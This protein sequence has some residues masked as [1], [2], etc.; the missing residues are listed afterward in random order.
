MKANFALSLS[1]DGI[2][3]LHRAAGGWRRVDG[4]DLS[5][6][7]LT[8]EL[9]SLRATALGLEPGGLRTKLIIP[10]DQIRYLK[11]T[12]GEIEEI[13]RRI[14]ARKALDGATP[15]AVE[16]L[17]F[18]ISADNEVTHIAAVARETL[19]EAE[20]FAVQYGFDPIC[21]VGIPGDEKFLGEPY[22]GQTA[23]AATFLVEGERV[24]P[25]GVAV[26]IVGDMSDFTGPSLEEI[27]DAPNFGEDTPEPATDHIPEAL[28]AEAEMGSAPGDVGALNFSSRRGRPELGG[29]TRGDIALSDA[30]R[31]SSSNSAGTLILPD[32][33]RRSGIRACR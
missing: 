2:A 27:E 32:L 4:V 8:A 19:G 33:P 6:A 7:D 10:A 18:D 11:I 14:A 12:T 25:D 20:A 17:E 15:Y 31:P 21:F 29:V 3:L 13:D 9:N 28:N 16:D 23:H 22:F 5:E 26:V 1:F 30:A 24:E